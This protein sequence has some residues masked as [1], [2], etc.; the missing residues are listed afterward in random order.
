[1]IWLDWLLAVCLPLGA[2]WTFVPFKIGELE[3]IAYFRRKL[4]IEGW[5]PRP[6]E[7]DEPPRDE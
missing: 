1:M 4:W 5:S 3:S 6:V 2:I 7:G